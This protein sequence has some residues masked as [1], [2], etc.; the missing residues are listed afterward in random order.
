MGDGALDLYGRGMGRGVPEK[1]LVFGRFMG[2]KRQQAVAVVVC[3][4]KAAYTPGSYIR[5][6]RS[7]HATWYVCM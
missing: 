5:G 7:M 2:I 4:R 1:G 3:R 6:V